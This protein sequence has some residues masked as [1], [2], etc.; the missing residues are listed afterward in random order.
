MGLGLVYWGINGRR[1][2]EA[3]ADTCGRTQSCRQLEVDP[4]RNKLIFADLSLGVGLVACGVAIWGFATGG[5]DNAAQP[6]GNSEQSATRTKATLELQG[7][8]ITA[9]LVF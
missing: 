1:D 2:A 8:S 3:L 4:V 9:R 6:H 5:S 7:S